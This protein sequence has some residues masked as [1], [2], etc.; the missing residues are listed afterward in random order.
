MTLGR[1]FILLAALYFVLRAAD[2]FAITECPEGIPL[3]GTEGAGESAMVNTGNAANAAGCNYK[4]FKKYRN[5]C[6]SNALFCTM[7]AISLSQMILDLKSGKSSRD[8]AQSFIPKESWP[9]YQP[10]GGGPTGAEIDNKIKFIENELPDLLKDLKSAGGPD[11]DPKT[12]KISTK[13][14]PMTAAQL[15][16]GGALADAGLIDPNLI[17]EADKLLA[18]NKSTR[19]KISLHMNAGV[20]GGG[21]R[22]P[23]STYTYDYDSSSGYNLDRYRDTPAPPKTAGLVKMVGGDPIGAATGN[24]FEMI[25]RTYQQKSAERIF[26]GQEEQ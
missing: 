9:T 4:G 14:G 5:Q 15:G 26:V 7:A 8:V 3:S 1:F 20:G 24:I 13:K 21:A 11:V 6:T 16:S 12:G 23:S 22:T 25:H 2:A 10:P 17:A 18:E 19:K